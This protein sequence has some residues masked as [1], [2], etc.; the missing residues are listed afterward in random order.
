MIFLR[1]CMKTQNLIFV[2]LLHTVMKSSQRATQ[3]HTLLMYS[4][5]HSCLIMSLLNTMALPRAHAKRKITFEYVDRLKRLRPVAGASVQGLRA[6]GLLAIYLATIRKRLTNRQLSYSWT[7]NW[8]TYR[9]LVVYRIS[10]R[11]CTIPHSGS[12]LGPRAV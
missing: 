4:M 2:K 7:T 12:A 9:R 3:S 11:P 6:L 1:F 5:N 8:L 10:P